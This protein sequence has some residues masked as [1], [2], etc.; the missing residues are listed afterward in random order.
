[1]E[2]LAL[3]TRP[4][5]IRL[6]DY[7]TLTKPRIISLLA[8]TAF[9]AMVVAQGRIPSMA[10]TVNTLS[11]LALSIGGAHAINMWYDRDIDRLMERTRHRPLPSGRMAPSEVLSFGIFL[12]SAS[13]VWL[14]SR[15][16]LLA[17][18]T[19]FAGFLFYVLIY[20]VWLKRRSPQNIVIGGAAGS[21][22][23][24]VGW[25]AA[26][27]HLGWTPW[28]MFLVIFLWTPPHF[29]AL[30]LYKRQDYQRANIPMMPVVKGS[31]TTI[32]Q[33]VLYA[34]LLIPCT[35]ALHWTDARLGWLYIVLA[36]LLGVIFWMLTA[37]LSLPHP[38]ITPER[39]FFAS[40]LYMAGIFTAVVVATLAG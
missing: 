23:P 30:A 40:L 15:V 3:A 29:W 32:R 27:N 21:F 22:P 34:T 8:I 14:A 7:V 20:T 28:L 2:H 9:C 12:Q 24:L 16:N 37:A 25:A 19:S 10:L 18:E 11:G 35:L 1:M 5:S 39:V 6:K 33:M 26:T 31:R 17:A 36:L 38:R 13:F 4:K